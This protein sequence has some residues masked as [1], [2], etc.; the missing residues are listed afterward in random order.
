MYR[1]R[2]RKENKGN[3]VNHPKNT[4]MSIFN[5]ATTPIMLFR[6]LSVPALFY[7][8]RKGAKFSFGALLITWGLSFIAPAHFN[9]ATETTIMIIYAIYSYIIAFLTGV[10]HISAW[11]TGKKVVN[12]NR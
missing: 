8:A 3:I 2:R 9:Y 12:K 6:I 11:F 1:R 4:F 5:A 10:L 7:L